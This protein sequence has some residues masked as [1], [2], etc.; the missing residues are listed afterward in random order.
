MAEVEKSFLGLSPHGF[1]R[2]AYGEW[3]RADN[4]R[5]VICVHGLTRNRHDF[6][7]LAR[8]LAP[9]WRVICP[10]IVGRGQSDWLAASA[11]YDIPQYVSDMSA[12][13]ARL[14][15]DEVCWVGTSMGGI[16]GMVLAAQAKTPIRRLVL[17]DVGG[18]IPK[19]A[20][21]RIRDYAAAEPLFDDTAQAQAWFRLNFAPFGPLSDAQWHD[22]AR[23]SLRET[24]EGKWRLHY[25]PGLT[26]ALTA[27]P[28]E[29]VA[30]WPIWDMIACPVMALRGEHSDLLSRDTLDEMTRRGPDCIT[31]EIPLCGHAPSLMDEAH[32]DLIRDF[33][34]KGE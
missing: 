6:D 4:R 29:D 17:N 8:A 24:P 18:F 13:I 34:E 31:H 27:K 15:V 23:H 14:D 33:L 32:I 19:A 30:L 10:D 11:L 9:D 20:L 3:G 1:H 25:D 28:P 16:I 21:E 2:I 22:L 12:L 5:V 26:Q 7:D